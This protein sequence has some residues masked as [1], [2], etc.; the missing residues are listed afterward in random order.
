MEKDII[1]RHT[2][3]ARW[4]APNDKMTIRVDYV[5]YMDEIACLLGV[6]PNL[7]KL[8]FTDP[9]LYWKLFWG[10]SLSYQYRLKGPHK[11]KGARDAI[12]TSKKKDCCFL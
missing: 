1:K 9:K 12:L 11:W 5:Q 10:P 4:Y 8:F 7:Y 6:K 2:R 3:N